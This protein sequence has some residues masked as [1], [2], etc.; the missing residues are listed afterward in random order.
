L[1]SNPIK[2]IIGFKYNKLTKRDG[3]SV[4]FQLTINPDDER[5]FGPCNCCGN[6]T[7]R[8]WGYVNEGDATIAAYFVEWTPGHVE[9]AATFD[10][11]LGKWGPETSSTDRQGAALAFR[12]LETGPTFMV[13]DAADRP[14]GASALVGAALSRE[15]IIGKPIAETVFAI[16]D[17]VFLQ[18]Q[19]ISPLR[20]RI[21]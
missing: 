17:T 3:S 16:C 10:L 9:Q 19:R 8:V 11:I 12:Q 7:R 5:T 18:D 1:T 6:M 14:I 2:T 21:G 13:L 20:E 4:T 15:Q